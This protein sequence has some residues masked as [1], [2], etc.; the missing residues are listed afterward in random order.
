MLSI[1]IAQNRA[2]AAALERTIEAA[3]STGLD[4]VVLT[5]SSSSSERGEGVFSAQR[6]ADEMKAS[7]S[8]RCIVID[9]RLAPSNADL[10]T[11]VGAIS[12][13]RSASMSYIPLR[14][15]RGI[16]DIANLKTDSL[17]DFL[18]QSPQWPVMCVG[19][20]R[21]LAQQIQSINIDNLSELL[22]TLM[23][24]ATVDNM[25]VA[26]ASTPMR[27][28]EQ[29]SMALSGEA[30]ARIT[31]SLIANC[32]IEDLFPNH[33]WSNHSEESAAASYHALAALFVRFGQMD[34]ATE[35]LR[36]SDS[37][38]DS[39]RSLAL[40]ALI[41][42]RQGEMLGAVANIVASLQ[43]YETRKNN[44]G[45]HYLSFNPENEAIMS[46]ELEAGLSALNKSD[47][48]LA[49]RHFSKVVFGF[50]PLFRSVGLAG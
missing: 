27:M 30:L 31:S 33:P 28:G 14:S 25:V 32:N 37:L 39:P 24:M 45:S 5:D 29:K 8:Q 47:N 6:L 15:Q 46:T 10:Q 2:S 23:V 26:A 16:V 11:A 40:R 38:E 50:D 18:A 1:I 12:R 7:T 35:C 36:L 22:A 9:A 13:V 21:G 44:D 42:E 3:Q 20:D 41:A 49:Y 34:S 19:L 17:V 4:T 43:Q 48:S